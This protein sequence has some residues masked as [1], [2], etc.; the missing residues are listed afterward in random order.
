METAGWVSTVGAMVGG[1]VD[2]A[3]A[4]MAVL[5][6]VR[7]GRHTLLQLRAGVQADRLPAGG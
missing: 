2:V 4:M 6:V 1:V 3:V 7:L 5:M